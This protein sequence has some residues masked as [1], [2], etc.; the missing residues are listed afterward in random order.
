MGSV[1]EALAPDF[2]VQTNDLLGFTTS[3][4][5]ARFTATA[6]RPS[7]GDAIH[8]LIPR[9]SSQTKELRAR[10]SRRLRAEKRALDGTY[11]DLASW[12]RTAP[13]VGV[14]T[15][16]RRAAADA[17]KRRARDRYCL[18][19]LYF[20]SGYFSTLQAIEIDALRY[21]IDRQSDPT[22]K[23][24]LLS[25]WMS[26]AGTVM[27]APG[28]SAQFLKP[29]NHQIFERIRR[30]W[31]R[32]VWGLFVE[33]LQTITPIGTRAWRSNNA[34]TEVDALDLVDRGDLA[35]AGAVY[36]DPPYTKD[37][38]SRYYHVYETLYRYD[39]PDSAGAARARSDRFSTGFC[40]ASGVESSFRRLLEGVATLNLPLVLSY[41]S[42]GLLPRADNTVGEIARAAF[43]DV[44]RRTIQHHHSTMGGSAGTKLKT[45]MENIYVC[46]P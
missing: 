38:Y 44:R 9:Y 45:A 43:S 22:L 30:H 34:V 46:C 25:A 18:A 16:Y 12:M 28:H 26:A 23:D 17:S 27:N 41:P 10:F 11:R 36:A 39:F 13:H 33:R 35:D 42:D 7:V 15:H 37:Q 5:R 4:A 20:S 14:S 8:H 3:F 24:W 29:T 21:A 40:L 32:S 19:T 2:H 6:V 31:H 1:A